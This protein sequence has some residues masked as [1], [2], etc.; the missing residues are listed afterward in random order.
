[1]GTL[2][3]RAFIVTPPWTVGFAQ[4]KTK[5]AVKTM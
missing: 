5:G 3:V 4:Q 1:V 2:R